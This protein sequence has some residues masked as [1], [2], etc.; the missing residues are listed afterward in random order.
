MAHIKITIYAMLLCLLFPAAFAQQKEAQSGRILI[1]TGETAPD[2][3]LSAWMQAQSYQLYRNIPELGLQ[4]WAPIREAQSFEALS[5]RLHR[6]FPDMLRQERILMEADVQYESQMIPNDPE[7]YRQWSLRNTGQYAP[8]SLASIQAT[9]AWELQQ[10]DSSV[11]VGVIDSGID[12][13]HPDLIHNIWQNLGEDLDGDGRVLEF[14]DGQWQFDPDDEDGLDTDG[15]GY[16][17]DFIGWDFVNNDN[18]PTDDHIFGHGTHVAGIIAAEGNNGIGVSG[19][20]WHATLMPLKFLNAQGN[21]FSSDAIAALSYAHAMGAHLT[22]NSWGSGVFSQLMLE[23]IAAY[24]RPFVAAAG[25]NYGNNNDLA[26]LFP[27]SYDL[28]NILAVAASDFQDQLASFSNTGAF[29]VDFAAPGVGIYSTLPGGRYGFLNGTSMAAPHVSGAVCLLLSDEPDLSAE[30]VKDRFFRSVDAV[31]AMQAKTVSG[32]RLNVFRLLQRPISFQAQLSDANLRATGLARS[33]GQGYMILAQNGDMAEIIQLNA[34]GEWQQAQVFTQQGRQ[35]FSHGFQADDGKW[36]LAGQTEFSGQQHAVLSLLDESAALLWQKQ[37]GTDGADA[38]Q[39][40]LMGEDGKVYALGSSRGGSL[41]TEALLLVQLDNAGN[42]LWQK[43]FVAGFSDLEISGAV[44]TRDGGLMGLASSRSSGNFRAVLF[45]IAANGSMEWARYWHLPAYTDTRGMG[46]IAEE[47]ELNDDDHDPLDDEFQMA[48]LAENGNDTQ[49]LV[50][51]INALGHATDVENY[52]LPSLRGPIGIQ[53]I[54]GDGFQLSGS[55]E[56]VQGTSVWMA[57]SDKH[58]IIQ[59]SR[60][61]FADST[62][63]FALT[64][65]HTLDGG[66]ALLANRESGGLQLVKAD[67]VGNSGCLEAELAL[68]HLSDQWPQATAVTLQQGMPNLAVQNMNPRLNA[69]ASSMDILCS[70]AHCQVRAIISPEDIRT[71]R[72][73]SLQFT[74]LSTQATSLEWKV[75]GIT[76]SNAQQFSYTFDNKGTYEVILIARDA[77]CAD[78]AKVSITVEDK[79][80]LN[81]MDSTLCAP[82]MVLDAGIPH[83]SYEW[84][85][86]NTGELLGTERQLRVTQSREVQLF[87]VDECGNEDDDKML[88]NL[89]GDCVWPGDVTADGIVDILDFLTLGTVHGTLGPARPNASPAFIPQDGPAWAES[90][91]PSNAWAAG[92]NLKHA[93][94]DGDGEVNILQDAQLIE[95]NATDGSAS[96]VST[97]LSPLSLHLEAAQNTVNL[98]DTLFFDLVLENTAGGMVEDAYGVAF[99]LDYNL[100]LSSLPLIQTDSSWLGGDAAPLARMSLANRRNRRIQFGIARYN[101]RGVTGGGRIARGGVVIFVED[102]GELGALSESAFFTISIS[103]AVLIRPDGTQIPVNHLNTQNTQSFVVRIPRVKLELQAYLQGGYDSTTHSMRT[104]LQQNNLLPRMQ[105]YPQAD[106]LS[107]S[108]F[109]PQVVDWVLIELRDKND[110]G[111]AG[112]KAFIPALLLEDGHIVDPRTYKAPE[113]FVEPDDYYVL[114]H[115]R[116]HLRVM[117]PAPVPISTQGKLHWDFSTGPGQAAGEAQL[118][119]LEGGKYGLYAG[120]INQDGHISQSGPGNDRRLILLRLGGNDP[121]MVVNG[122]WNEDLNLDGKVDYLGHNCDRTTLRNTIGSTLN[123]VIESV[124][125]E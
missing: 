33:R 115:H 4:V 25:N 14:I 121:G 69:L 79:P 80:K 40:V 123:R 57:Q 28:P 81:L 71:C 26:P 111:P 78:Q 37:Y 124:I 118:V 30:M 95:Q 106:T 116:N 94:C 17:D 56:D 122:Y 16:A 93:D 12:W 50:V 64:L 91:P 102:I 73:G 86:K 70:N 107:A 6:Q 63:L 23:A 15:N 119:R 117:T 61:Y 31:P 58:G 112:S 47:R 100:P 10:G 89:T 5:A 3:R 62:S 110:P 24:G 52:R 49:L 109:S 67:V 98:G 8:N 2:N 66:A 77:D 125:E 60:R 101:R 74:S 99:Q 32:G 18:D 43:T 96:I 120:D 103:Q 87:V 82:A 51:E 11:V 105:P 27:A 20:S 34:R 54:A 65:Q 48:L 83:L 84:R 88:V 19:V 72:G 22:N 97:E 41:G 9:E 42:L 55:V 35:Q 45:K 1:K 76:M 90:F 108:F 85:D 38:F 7:F 68:T 21:G 36:W 75:N 113:A 104:S 39:H 53:H 59:W 44:A 29:S 114:L 13:Q 46:I 92:V